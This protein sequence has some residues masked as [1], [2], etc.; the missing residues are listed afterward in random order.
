MKISGGAHTTLFDTGNVNALLRTGLELGYERFQYGRGTFSFQAVPATLGLETSWHLERH[1]RPMSVGIG[2]AAS[3]VALSRTLIKYDPAPTSSKANASVVEINPDKKISG[4][5]LEVA[6]HFGF[7]TNLVVF[8]S[9]SNIRHQHQLSVIWSSINRSASDF[10][11]EHVP[12][13]DELKRFDLNMK[14]TAWALRWSER[15]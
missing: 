15:I 7:S 3:K 12:S 10:M 11:F 6:A 1:E 2:F 8:D 14:S 13:T 9:T 4:Q 5:D